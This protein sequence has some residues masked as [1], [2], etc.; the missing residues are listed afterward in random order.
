MVYDELT[1]RVFYFYS[2]EEN[3]RGFRLFPTESKPKREIRRGQQNKME[4]NGE[5]STLIEGVIKKF[6]NANFLFK[7]E[8]L[9]S[10]EPVNNLV[11]THKILIQSSEVRVYLTLKIYN[12][13]KIKFDC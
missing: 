2:K 7:R 12:I 13:C 10:F 3:R 5:N 9:K 8:I 4:L 6:P 11:K 1:K